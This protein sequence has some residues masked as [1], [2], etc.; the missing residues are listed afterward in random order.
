[1]VSLPAKREAV[2]VACVEGHLSERRACRLL[3]MHR[4]SCRYRPRERNE[5]ALRARLR[6]I[7]AERPRFGYCQRAFRTDPF[8][9]I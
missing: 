5:Q 7:A 1:M 6:E 2:R 9:R 4:G 3:R 8:A